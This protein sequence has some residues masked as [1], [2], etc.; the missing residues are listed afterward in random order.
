M[1]PP[2]PQAA[3]EQ[4]NLPPSCLPRIPRAVWISIKV[5]IATRAWSSPAP[6]VGIASWISIPEAKEESI[7]LSQA[8][9]RSILHG[10]GV[11]LRCC[12]LLCKVVGLERW[13][14]MRRGL[15]PNRASSWAEGSD[16]LCEG[17]SLR[18]KKPN[19]SIMFWLVEC[20][21]V[22]ME[23]LWFMSVFY[24]IA[25]P[26]FTCTAIGTSLLECSSWGCF[27][28]FLGIPIDIYFGQVLQLLSSRHWVN[29]VFSKPCFSL[30]DFYVCNK[31]SN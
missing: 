7:R 8:N 24:S 5:Y 21:Y 25:C 12:T 27:R 11:V 19:L 15:H 22:Q 23:W 3:S 18:T 1:D 29:C 31:G 6:L 13:P 14:W 17:S 28:T 9:W 30:L 10:F 16:D 26:C 20:F 2:E 4:S